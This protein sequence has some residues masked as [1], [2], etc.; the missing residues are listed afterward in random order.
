MTSSNI[1]ESELPK[2]IL[3]QVTIP[4][5]EK[6]FMHQVIHRKKMWISLLMNSTK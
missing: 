5:T 6:H 4:A 2:K 1:S 3:P